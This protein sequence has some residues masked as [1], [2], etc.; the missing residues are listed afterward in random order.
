MIFAAGF[1]ASALEVVLLLAFQVLY[2]SLYRQVGL[3]V[4]V[5][6]TGLAAGAW[7]AGRR[8]GRW[9]AL[10][11]TRSGVLGSSRST[12]SRHRLA[13]LAFAIA[14][15]AALLPLVLPRLGR[16]D[17]LLGGELGGQAV[18]LG[19]AFV[20]AALVGH[21]FAQAAAAESG[22]PAVAAA[23]LYSADLAG[24]ALGALLVSAWLVPL[25][26]VT[27]VCLLTAGL[28]AAAGAIAWGRTTPA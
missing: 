1:A 27:T 24:A 21:Q 2:G 11:A 9:N 25:F 7:W 3:V 28:N 22:G 16:L 20:L 5:F 6:M 18:I 15:F 8:P 17:D 26:G 12:F 13:V 4:T 23:R 19:L 10:T 14:T